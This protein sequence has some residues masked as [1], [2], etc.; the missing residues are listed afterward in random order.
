MAKKKAPGDETEPGTRQSAENI[1]RRCSGTG[2]VD[3]RPCRDC[4]GSGR[5][6]VIV[7]DA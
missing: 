4:G 5:V 3:G 1:C 6:T 7:G 2:K